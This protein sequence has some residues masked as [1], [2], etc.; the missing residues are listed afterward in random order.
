MKRA[1]VRILYGELNNPNHDY[2][3]HRSHIDSSIEKTVNHKEVQEF[4]T[5]C[6]GEYN[7]KYLVSIGCKNI[8]LADKN[9][10][11][12]G[13]VPYSYL[14]KIHG[15][16]YAMEDYDEVVFL[17]WDT[18]Q[19]KPF[20]IDFWDVLS[21]KEKIQAALANNIKSILP[22]RKYRPNRDGKKAPNGSF[23]YMRDKSI[24]SELLKLKDDLEFNK[25][26]NIGKSVASL[27]IKPTIQ[28]NDEVYIARYMDNICGGWEGYDKYLKLFDPKWC[29]VKWEAFEK[30]EACFKH[31]L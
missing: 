16:K 5:Y 31:P 8:V 15:W 27:S 30:P 12:D 22:W 11:I 6:F 19:I 25:V 26:V 23:V 20:P 14:N 18:V 24:P 17:D 9:P 4:V 1:L 3:L 10:W 21:Q 7:Y 28:H 13:E 29:S 2:L